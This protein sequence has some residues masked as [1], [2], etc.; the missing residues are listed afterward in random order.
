EI[1]EEDKEKPSQSKERGYSETVALPLPQSLASQGALQ[2]R[3]AN[4]RHAAGRIRAL[5]L[6]SRQSTKRRQHLLHRLWAVRL[7]A[8]DVACQLESPTAQQ[9]AWTDQVIQSRVGHSLVADL[10]GGAQQASMHRINFLLERLRQ[11]PGL[12]VVQQERSRSPPGTTPAPPSGGQ[13]ALQGRVA[14]ERHGRRPNPGAGVSQQAVDETPSARLPSPQHLLHR[15]WAVRLGADDVACQL[16]SPTAQQVAWTDQV[17]QSRVGHSLVADLEGGAQQ[18]S[19]HRINFFARATPSASRSRRCTAGR[20]RSPPGTTPA[21]PS[22]GQASA[23][24][25]PQI[26]ADAGN[27]TAEV[28]ELLTTRKLLH[29]GRDSTSAAKMQ[30]SVL[31]PMLALLMAAL[32]CA[33]STRADSLHHHGASDQEL[34][35]QTEKRA[36]FDPMG[37]GKR[38]YFDPM[39]YGKKKRAYFDPMGYGKK[40]RAYFDPMGYGKKKKGLLRLSTTLISTPS[41][42]FC[43]K[44]C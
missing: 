27:Q 6:A 32:I 11:R 25:T 10:E 13:G 34:Q 3:V 23:A 43:D 8:D 21:P 38:A 17:I 35:D 28:D 31:A 5:A 37:Y 7:G 42:Q 33:S 4:E 9:V 16:E 30:C 12:G 40:K 15:L 44:I 14:N 39:G 18:A 20:S 36:Y 22:G 24:A 1:K 29:P 26:L 19:M 2:G 41:L